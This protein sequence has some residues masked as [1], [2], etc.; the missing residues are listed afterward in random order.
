[1]RLPA[2]VAFGASLVL[3]VSATGCAAGDHDE[4]AVSSTSPTPENVPTGA[5]SPT[6]ATAQTTTA[7]TMTVPPTTVPPTTVPPTTV[8][9]ATVPPATVPPATVP[10]AT[11]ASADAELAAAIQRDA[12]AAEAA[13]LT[14]IATPAD[15]SSEALVRRYYAG[16][17]LARVLEALTFLVENG[18]IGRPN[19]EVP[20]VLIITGEPRPVG[21]TG[22]EIE[23]T[24]CRVD[25]AVILLPLSDDPN[26]PT[27]VYNDRI[28]RT[29]ATTRFSLA[30]GIWRI[31]GGTTIS[32]SEGDT[33]CD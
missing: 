25:A 4:S 27:A 3:A 9:P 26:G 16:D 19:P 15:P 21:G 11:V 17:S 6:A 30:D 1:M 24:T 8:P 28:T 33:T 10:P 32:E 5:T 2:R 22:S 31:E 23:V 13:L 18:L 29:E 14:A 12:T 20:S 7:P